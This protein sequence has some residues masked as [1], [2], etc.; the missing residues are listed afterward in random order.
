MKYKKYNNKSIKEIKQENVERKIP[1]D[2]DDDELADRLSSFN[3]WLSEIAQKYGLNHKDL[4]IMI[5][6]FKNGATIEQMAQFAMQQKQL[7]EQTYAEACQKIADEKAGGRGSYH[8]YKGRN[9]PQR[10]LDDGYER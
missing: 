6:M 10:E 9:N 4:K 1:T 3:R 7:H 2:I 5:E 8:G